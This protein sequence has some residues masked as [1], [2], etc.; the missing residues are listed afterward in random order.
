MVAAMR[1]ALFLLPTDLMGGA[2]KVLRLT[3]EAAARAGLFDRV[4]VFVLAGPPSGSLDALAAQG[5]EVV[6]ARA[7]TQRA[8]LPALLRT[9][10]RERYTLV[11]STHSHLNAA[12]SA[13]RKL[14]LLRT[15]RLVARESTLIFE[16]DLGPTGRLVRGLYHLYG[17]Q[18]RIVCQTERM[19]RSLQKHTR[20]RFAAATR[21]VPNPVEATSRVLAKPPA[22]TFDIVWCGRLAPVK[23][24][25]RALGALQRLRAQGHD[26]RLTIL[27]DGPLRSALERR[28]VDLGIE[29]ATTFAGRVADP[30]ARMAEHDLGLLTS[31]IEG[32]PNVVLEMLAAGVRRV[33]TTDCA[34]GLREIPGVLVAP[35]NPHAL[36]TA[37]LEAHA[38]PAPTGLDAFLAERS[39]DAFLQAIVA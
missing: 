31:D 18:D 19:A 11:F 15:R 9:F 35:H 24:P 28:A 20:G 36:A 38:T 22:E 5:A 14:G 37:L 23:A 12:A 10:S 26:A 39:P 34:G 1:T 4:V 30:K 33:V 29:D 3:A 16:R 13:A 21:H 6:H 17:A 7:R 25:E 32:F 8:A 2:E 27:G